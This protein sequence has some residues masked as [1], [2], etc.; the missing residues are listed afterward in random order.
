MSYAEMRR[1]RISSSFAT[2][3]STIGRTNWRFHSP[4]PVMTASWT[5]SCVFAVSIFL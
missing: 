4:I 1:I 2:S 3:S 5:F